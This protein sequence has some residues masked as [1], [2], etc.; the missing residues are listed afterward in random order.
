M[1]SFLV[2]FLYLLGGKELKLF[3]HGYSYLVWL[4]ATCLLILS[5]SFYMCSTVHSAACTC[6]SFHSSTFCTPASEVP[7]GHSSV[8]MPSSSWLLWE[9]VMGKGLFGSSVHS[10]QSVLG[11]VYRLECVLHNQN[12]QVFL[13]PFLS[14]CLLSSAISDLLFPSGF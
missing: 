1:G 11:L 6:F 14:K 2:D 10:L 7:G 12:L 4:T 9:A 3:F 8:L 13:V 5:L